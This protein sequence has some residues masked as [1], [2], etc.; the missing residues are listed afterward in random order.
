MYVQKAS[1]TLPDT[2]YLATQS[3][4]RHDIVKQMGLSYVSIPNKLEDEQFPESGTPQQKAEAL[5]VQKASLSAEGLASGF[6]LGTDTIV[7]LGET[8][9]GK[10]IGPGG[11]A[12]MLSLLSG[13]THTVITAMCLFNAETQAYRV[14]SGVAHVTFS[15]LTS[16]DILA[17]IAE[18]EPFD[19]AGSYGIQDIPAHFL[20]RLDGEIDSVMGLCSKTLNQLISSMVE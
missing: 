11:A 20:E 12:E 9:L 10:P 5:A 3:P 7:V 18:A 13:V 8:L 4:R 19:K 1:Q 17:Y 16:D 14:K 15:P 6:V 2:L